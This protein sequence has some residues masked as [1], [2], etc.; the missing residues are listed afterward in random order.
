MLDSNQGLSFFIA[1]SVLSELL[2]WLPNFEDAYSEEFSE[3]KY[4]E[5]NG[6]TF[7]R[8]CGSKEQDS[9]STQKTRVSDQQ[10]KNYKFEDIKNNYVCLIM[11]TSTY[12]KM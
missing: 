5:K 4:L 1:V 8:H 3:Y 6:W 7:L 12:Q 9:G 10:G 11:Y 2:T